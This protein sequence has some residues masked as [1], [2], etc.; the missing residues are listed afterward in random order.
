MEVLSKDQSFR[1]GVRDP[2]ALQD[3]GRALSVS[4]L[5][6]SEPLAELSSAAGHTVL[7]LNSPIHGFLSTFPRVPSDLGRRSVTCLSQV[8]A[9]PPDPGTDCCQN[10][11]TSGGL[12]W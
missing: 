5:G 7:F 8:S 10:K 4:S 3:A 12:S 6:W 9:A 1:S 2:L 11:T